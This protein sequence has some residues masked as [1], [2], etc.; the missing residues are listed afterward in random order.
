MIHGP[1]GT[2]FPNAPCMVDSDHGKKC[3]KKF[4]NEFNPETILNEDG[5]PIYRRH[6]NVTTFTKTINGQTVTFDNRHVVSYTTHR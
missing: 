3:K 5:Y 2:N 6:G 4:P 1:C